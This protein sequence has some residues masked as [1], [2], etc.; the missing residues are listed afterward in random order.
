MFIIHNISFIHYK[1]C[2]SFYFLRK[3]IHKIICMFNKK[4]IL[5][6]GKNDQAGG[7]ETYF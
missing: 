3:A 1:V 5:L 2:L 7:P 4:N 6:L